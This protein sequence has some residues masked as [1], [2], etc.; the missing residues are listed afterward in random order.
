MRALEDSSVLAL[1]GPWGSGKSSLINLVCERIGASWQVR[2]FS[3]WAPPDVSALLADLFATI[4]SALPE[5]ERTRWLKDLLV[6]YAQLAVPVLG[7]IPVV[8]SAAQGVAANLVQ[9]R[10]DR[11]MQSMFDEL[12]A[13]LSDLG[14][15]VL[16]V[17]DDVDRLQPDELLALLKAI[18]LLARFPGVYYLLAYDEQTII[19][20]LT[21]T[22]VAQNSS[23]RALAYLEKIVQVRLD[24]PPAQRFYTEQMLGSGI[25]GL[26]D[27]LGIPL[28]PEQT[29]RFRVLYDTL[30]QFTL[31]QPRATGRFLR[32]AVAYLP[33][34]EPGEIDVVDFLALTHLRSL[35]PATYRLLARSRSLLGVP[36]SGPV[37]PPPDAVREAVEKSLA[38]ECADYKD[39]VFA[40]IAELFPFL[41][42]D[43]L[44]HLQPADWQ[45]RAATRRAAI[46]EY[47]DRYFLFGLSADDI[48]DAAV[49]DA[50][51]AIARNEQSPARAKVEAHLTG[52]DPDRADRAVRKLIRFSSLPGD[53]DTRDLV[54][55]LG[56][57]LA[58][59]GRARL[60]DRLLG[61][62]EH[63]GVTWATALITRLNDAGQC[64]D[65]GFAA[66]L[67]NA[68]F[69]VL[70]QALRNAV[71]R[72]R[73]GIAA[74]MTAYELAAR[75]ACDRIRAHL[76]ERD[77]ADRD[78][79][80]PLLVQFVN[81]TASRAVLAEMISYDLGEGSFALADLAARFVTVGWFQGEREELIGFDDETLIALMGLPPLWSFSETGQDQDPSTG[82]PVDEQDVSWPSRCRAGLDQLRKALLE[83]RAVPPRAPS[84]VRT[85]PQMSPVQQ[86]SPAQWGSQISHALPTGDD[87][88]SLLCIRAA[89]LL[90][91]AASGLPSGVG[92]MTLSEEARAQ[93]LARILA[94]TTFTAWCRDRARA[95]GLALGPAWSESGNDNRIF[96]ELVL[97]GPESDDQSPLRAHCMISAG[98]S[99]PAPDALGIGLDL[100]L[101]LPLPSGA[102]QQE[103]GS[104]PRGDKLSIQEL[105]EISET[106]IWSAILVARKA[107]R[108][109][110]GLSSD[111]GHLAV[112]L[113]ARQ[114]LDD[115]IDLNVFPTVGNQAA[116]HCP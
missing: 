83:Q 40:V 81:R 67:G 84:G 6:E 79:P 88:G 104:I 16:V 58:M 47:F 50:L 13:Q 110:L 55:V 49:R 30:L 45:L 77:Q 19:D 114:S 51:T 17:L 95:S 111:D 20:V 52:A 39:Q 29:V 48:A 106:I 3:T 113:A 91:G 33:M 24:I 66:E 76:R 99:S 115:V 63:H 56:Y 73:E 44:E 101:S 75:S 4:R 34:P 109:L 60:P 108:E 65:S 116:P 23:D 102:G 18:R 21:T 35:A 105:V 78:F 70:C 27:R 22:A 7:V 43:Y 112:W 53:L 36:P 74:L 80:V 96:A 46:E 87:P 57:A 28:S 69:S 8:G 25:T 26:L 14:L 85:V 103:V 82:G 71:L 68:E 31:S 2:Y 10:A 41:A 100:I 37:G 12:T 86:T 5:G 89:V 9:L 59:P 94:E 90:P 97:N 15:R 32:Q 107:A 42:G 93:V 54:A 11:P 1:V 38:E 64:L 72:Q 61:S 92:S 98:S 62:P